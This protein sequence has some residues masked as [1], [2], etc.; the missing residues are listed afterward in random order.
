[1]QSLTR[2]L[3]SVGSSQ[4]VSYNS[5]AKTTTH[6]PDNVDMVF[7]FTIIKP[8]SIIAKHSLYM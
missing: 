1:M 6:C 8:G 4:A 3:G 2:S 5:Y 7:L